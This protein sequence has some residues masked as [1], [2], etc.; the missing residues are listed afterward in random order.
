M[1]VVDTSVFVVAL[2]MRDRR[3][4]ASLHT[5]RGGVCGVVLAELLHGVRTPSERA[6]LMSVVNALPPIPI[7]ESLWV[8]LGDNLAKLR[9]AGLAVPFP[10]A[11]IASIATANNFEL[12]ARDG[13]YKMIQTVLPS[14]RLFQEQP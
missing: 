11:V 8:T 4:I 9:A 10:D 12:W 6:H 2:R 7:E 1:I 14:L 3:L 5:N 13:H